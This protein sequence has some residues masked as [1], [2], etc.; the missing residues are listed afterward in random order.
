MLKIIRRL[1]SGQVAEPAALDDEGV[2]GLHSDSV[3]HCLRVSYAR[4][5]AAIREGARSIGDLQR[6]TSACSRCFGCRFE[7]ERMLRQHLGDGYR[8]ERTISLPR[9]YATQRIPQPM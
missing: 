5:E 9:D 6:A 4:V 7:L 2:G 1:G 8:A 3:C